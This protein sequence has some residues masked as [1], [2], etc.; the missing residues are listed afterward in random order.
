MKFKLGMKMTK[1]IPVIFHYLK[2]YDSHLLL[3]E[4]G[5]FTEKI[6]V[7]PNNYNKKQDCL[8]RVVMVTHE[9]PQISNCNIQFYFK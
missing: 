3:S 8:S 4:L 1:T 9:K 6:S 7:I 5:K 2:E